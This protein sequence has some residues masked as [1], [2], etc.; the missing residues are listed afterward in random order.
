VN[1]ITFW[2]GSGLEFMPVAIV[3]NGFLS[4]TFAYRPCDTTVIK[5]VH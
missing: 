5:T 2:S 1:S 4:G 3:P